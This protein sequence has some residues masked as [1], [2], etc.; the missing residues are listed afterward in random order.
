MA[1]ATVVSI[2]IFDGVHLGHQAIIARARQLA[3][4]RG[5]RTVAITF[6]PFP[7]HVLR[8]DREPLRLTNIDER[9]RR[10]HQAGADRVLVIQPTREF[11]SLAPEQ[12]VRLLVAEHKPAV[13]VEGPNF[14]FGKGRQGDTSALAAL[15]TA[16]GFQAVVVPQLSITLSDL[17]VAPLSSSLVRWLIAQ[18]RTLEA[19]KAL[20]RHY[21]LEGTVVVGAQRGRT[22][23]V[24]TVNLDPADVAGRAIPCDGVYAGR[25][26]LP[27]GRTYAAAISIGIKPTMRP[28]GG[29]PTARTI[30]AHLLDFAG[31]LYGSSIVLHFGRWL[32]DQQAFPGLPALRRQLQRDIAQV[33]D[34]ARHGMLS[35]SGGGTA[36]PDSAAPQ[37]GIRA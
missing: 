35:S 10:M 4:E 7:A 12:F 34:L 11:L 3:A 1:D 26:E 31:D 2:G 18:G 5:L 23:D 17:T 36:A 32:R 24:P 25:G 13:I 21:T 14:H 9:A 20:G 8:P 33:R 22:L 27:D 30:E 15:S 28:A 6:D 29:A 37:A 16:L 19:A